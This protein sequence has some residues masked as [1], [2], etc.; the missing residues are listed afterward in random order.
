MGIGLLDP[1]SPGHDLAAE[2][3]SILG[4]DLV[5]LACQGGPE[6]IRAT[7]VAQPLLLLH[8]V[9]VLFQLPAEVRSS[10]VAVAGHSLG[11]YTGLVATGALEWQEALALVRERG[12]AM[13]AAASPGQGMS[14]VLAMDGPRV[15][16]V[17]AELG[18]ADVVIAN[19]NAP[20]QVVLSGQMEGLEVAAEALRAAGARKVIPLA[21]GGAFHSPL[22]QPAAERLDAALA[23][24][25]LQD[26]RAPQ[27]FNVDGALR[28]RAEDIRSA[29][30]AQLTASVRW[31]DCIEGLVRAGCDSFVEVGPG[32]TLTAMGKRIAPACRWQSVAGPE[33][34]LALA[35][36]R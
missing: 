25:R 34:A 1:G 30:R 26:G 12:L 19:I 8:S 35:G 16:E 21:V 10:V 3:S 6:S 24:A 22:M 11:E 15:S 27:A 2:A 5:G 28:T 7:D 17:L 32:S 20:G 29:L 9:A 33:G 18:R 31:T 4:I 13:A 36:A 14:A 23:A